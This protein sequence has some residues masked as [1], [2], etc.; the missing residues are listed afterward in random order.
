MDAFLN[1]LCDA[2]D[3][4]H[5][6]VAALPTGRAARTGVEL[7]DLAE[8]PFAGLL[9]ASLACDHCHESHTWNQKHAWIERAQASR[10]H[11]RPAIGAQKP[12][13]AQ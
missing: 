12:Q 9:P 3:F 4:E 7:T 10:L 5:Q 2:H 13:A 6:L 1:E 8:F 11:V